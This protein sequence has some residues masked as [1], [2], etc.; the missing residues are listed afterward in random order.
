MALIIGIIGEGI[1][2][3]LDDDDKVELDVKDGVLL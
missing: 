2:D 3:W 1:E